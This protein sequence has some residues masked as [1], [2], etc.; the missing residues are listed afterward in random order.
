MASYGPASCTAIHSDAENTPNLTPACQSSHCESHSEPLLS[1]SKNEETSHSHSHSHS[2]S[3]DAHSLEVPLLPHNHDWNESKISGIP[4]GSKLDR[5]SALHLHSHEST[6]S[7]IMIPGQSGMSY[8]LASL[9]SIHSF[10]FGA[11]LGASTSVNGTLT[12]L[13]ALLAHKGAEAFAVGAEVSKK[14][15]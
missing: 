13:V 3:Y 4:G 7:H 10:I 14:V 1:H 2:H 8:I 9:F 11:A 12:L 6:H 5:C 15:F